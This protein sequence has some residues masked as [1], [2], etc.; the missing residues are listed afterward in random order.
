MKLEG[1]SRVCT[2]RILQSW[3]LRFPVNGRWTRSLNFSGI[4]RCTS[5]DRRSS[6]ETFA[7]PSILTRIKK[8]NLA[9]ISW[10]N[11]ANRVVW[12]WLNR[13]SR[14]SIARES[15]ATRESFL[16]S[17]N[18]S[19]NASTLRTLALP[20]ARWIAN[21]PQGVCF[22]DLLAL[23]RELRAPSASYDRGHFIRY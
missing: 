14:D 23:F 19:C 5:L 3:I 20:Y 11:Y 1:F 12:A 22:R 21:F 6:L 7:R 18:V 15:G 8:L 17:G 16:I 4:S 9:S 2:F 13:V 10:R